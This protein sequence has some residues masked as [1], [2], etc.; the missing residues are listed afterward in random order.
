MTTLVNNQLTSEEVECLRG[1]YDRGFVVCIFT[2]EELGE[3]NPEDVQD[4]C[5]ASGWDRIE[6]E[7]PHA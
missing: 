4:A 2:P 6:T 3:A 5:I 1:L 7:R